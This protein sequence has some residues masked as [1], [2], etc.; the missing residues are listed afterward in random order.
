MS[1]INLNNNYNTQQINEQKNELPTVPKDSKI[2]KVAQVA[3][4]LAIPIFVLNSLDNLPK[5]DG[6]PVLEVTC[7]AAC[8]TAVAVAPAAG[9]AFWNTCMTICTALGFAPTP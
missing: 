8:C 1:A 6:G 3:Y 5:A 4:K 2:F 9:A 7:Y